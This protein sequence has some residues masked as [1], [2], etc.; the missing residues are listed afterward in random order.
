VA[1]GSADPGV[2]IGTSIFGAGCATV[3]GLVSVKILQ[4]LPRFKKDL[5]IDTPPTEVKNG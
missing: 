3:A 5:L 4:R 2:I 1:Q